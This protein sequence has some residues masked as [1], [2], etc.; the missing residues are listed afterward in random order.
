MNSKS[1]KQDR[2][3]KRHLWQSRKFADAC[4]D[5]V[6]NQRVE[7]LAVCAYYTALHIVDALYLLPAKK[8]KRKFFSDHKARIN[9]VQKDRKVLG[10]K[11]YQDFFSLYRF[12]YIARYLTQP[13]STRNKLHELRKNDVSEITKRLVRIFRRWGSMLPENLNALVPKQPTGS[14]IRKKK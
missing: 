6:G 2:R 9:Q 4:E 14:P 8:L 11:P 12:S 1:K 13:D 7:G 10:E 3:I 5:L